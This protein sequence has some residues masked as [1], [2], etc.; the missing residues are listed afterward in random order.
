M[1][2]TNNISLFIK[3]NDVEFRDLV[4]RQCVYLNYPGSPDDITQELYFRFLTTS[5]I[6][7]KF[8]AELDIQM[9]T[10]LFKIIKNFIISQ[11]KSHGGRFFRCRVVTPIPTNGVDEFDLVPH[12]YDVAEEFSNTLFYNNSCNDKNELVSE[13][14]EFER[15]FANSPQNI[16]YSLRKRK[17]KRKSINYLKVLNRLKERKKIGSEFYKIRDIISNIEK[18][19]C[20]LIDVF[21]LLYQGYNNKAISQIYGVSTTTISAMKNKLARAMIQ[22]GITP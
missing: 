4:K 22:H 18:N 15:C 11:L 10:Y 3:E 17:H 13:L 7:E 16:K 1:V 9:S 6:I 19:G 8:D 5:K 14:E 12:Y 2:P 21:R 20:K